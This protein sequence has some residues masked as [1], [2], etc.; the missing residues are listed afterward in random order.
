MLA[1]GCRSSV[2]LR[3]IVGCDT[4]ML[5]GDRAKCRD[6][7]EVPTWATTTWS[8]KVYVGLQASAAAFFFFRILH[9]H[10]MLNSI[11]GMQHARNLGALSA[12][13]AQTVRLG[14]LAHANN[15]S[16]HAPLVSP[17]G[18][19]VVTVRA[20]RRDYLSIL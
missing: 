13:H 5:A 12:A 19:V 15:V 18:G 3:S 20:A 9:Q 7:D 6:R 10:E 11:E 8:L 2:S 14:S 4:V 17:R 1:N 16:L